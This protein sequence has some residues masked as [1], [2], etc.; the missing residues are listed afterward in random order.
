ML[1]CMGHQGWCSYMCQTSGCICIHTHLACDVIFISIYWHRGR[2]S[3]SNPCYVHFGMSLTRLF[4]MGFVSSTFI[5][6]YS[7]INKVAYTLEHLTNSHTI[8]WKTISICVSI[9]SSQVDVSTYWGIYPYLYHHRASLLSWRRWMLD[10]ICALGIS[11]YDTGP[12]T[13]AWY[14]H[15]PMQT[16]PLCIDL[17]SIQVGGDFYRWGE[18]GFTHTVLN[19]AKFWHY[20]NNLHSVGFCILPYRASS[21][22]PR[23]SPW[24]DCGEGQTRAWA[25]AI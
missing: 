17:S 20:P 12:W 4:D 21:N 5:S 9:G 11:L 2:S 16:L 18:Q 25:S 22:K 19:P 24:L 7:S 23:S 8:L 15:L 6:A 3:W 13:P 10:E 1:L 14:M